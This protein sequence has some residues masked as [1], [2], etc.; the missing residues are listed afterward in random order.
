M[1]RNRI[2]LRRKENCRGREETCQWGN[3][4]GISSGVVKLALL[5]PMEL[6]EGHELWSNGTLGMRVED[7]V[8]DHYHVLLHILR[9]LI[10]VRTVAFFPIF[11]WYL[12]KWLWDLAKGPCCVSSALE[13]ITL[14]SNVKIGSQV[15]GP[16]AEFFSKDD[17]MKSF[18]STYE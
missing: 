11:V 2:N 5:W 4:V 9:A 18:E 17:T 14:N 10:A 15:L 1:S 13:S 12:G 6:G 3:V 8:L 7:L 16:C